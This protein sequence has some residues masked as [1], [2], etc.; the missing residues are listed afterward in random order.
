MRLQ[1][2]KTNKPD[3]NT[4]EDFRYDDS[5]CNGNGNS[6]DNNLDDINVLDI[7]KFQIANLEPFPRQSFTIQNNET[8][9]NNNICFVFSKYF[10]FFFIIIILG[11]I[12]LS[13]YYI[14]LKI[15]NNNELPMLTNNTYTITM[16]TSPIS[17]P[18]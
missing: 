17:I 3:I 2:I 11:F 5:D 13:I 4:N 14:N 6:R 12:T 10:K 8:N 15:D 18:L 7:A 16:T 1:K 9:K